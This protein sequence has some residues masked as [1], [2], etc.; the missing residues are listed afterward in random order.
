ME[1]GSK[2]PDFKLVSIDLKP[3]TNKDYEGKNLLLLFFPLAFTSVCTQEMC[4]A[5]ED[6]NTYKDLNAEIIGIS[7]DSPF[8]LKKF[9]EENK[10]EITLGSDFDRAVSTAFNTLFTDDF[11]GLTGFSKRSS[12]VIDKEGIIRYAATAESGQLPDF[13]KIKEVLQSL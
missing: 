3:I 1:I 11:L 13:A 2:A 4:L 6:I 8:V 9:G 12:Y 5:S 10:I 7:V